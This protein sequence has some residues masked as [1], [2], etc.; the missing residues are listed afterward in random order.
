[1]QQSQRKKKKNIMLAFKREKRDFD[2][3]FYQNININFTDVLFL[4]RTNLSW[5]NI[6]A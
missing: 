4:L 6:C 1:M 3:S 5:E 2:G